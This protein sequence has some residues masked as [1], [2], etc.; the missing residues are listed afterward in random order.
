MEISIFK[1][2]QGD[3]IS[4]KLDG[5]VYSAAIQRL[6]NGNKGCFVYIDYP[7]MKQCVDFIPFHA[8]LN[9]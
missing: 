6:D 3:I 1:K 9:K 4:W 7:N 2:K 8:I 5:E